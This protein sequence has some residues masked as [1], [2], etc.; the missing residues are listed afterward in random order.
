[1][2]RSVLDSI[3]ERRS[4]SIGKII[5]ILQALLEFCSFGFLIFF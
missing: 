3:Y 2:G 4:N 1:M 5:A